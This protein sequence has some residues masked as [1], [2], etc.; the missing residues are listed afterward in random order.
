MAEPQG[1]A[2]PQPQYPSVPNADAHATGAAIRQ[3]VDAI[4][5]VLTDV[6][7]AFESSPFALLL[8]T[9]AGGGRPE[10]PA[11]A[12][13]GPTPNHILS[14][15][16]ETPLSQVEETAGHNKCPVCM[17]S[18]PAGAPVIRLPCNHVYHKD[19]IVP[20]LK[21][22][23]TCPVCRANLAEGEG[24]SMFVNATADVAE[25]MLE[26]ARY[27]AKLASGVLNPAATAATATTHAPASAPMPATFNTQPT[28]PTQPA[29]AAR[30]SIPLD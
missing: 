3:G 27:F 6:T 16:Q 26:A 21:R 10:Q 12:Y 29:P 19:C 4:E 20:W 25:E 23:S 17:D 7:T 28:Q 8:T 30:S 22:T 15:L 18:I 13:N 24:Q 5:N 9:L 11:H 1:A 14:R 2:H